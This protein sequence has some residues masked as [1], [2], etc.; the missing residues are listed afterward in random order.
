MRATLKTIAEATGFSINTVS[1]VLRNDGRI[2]QE[3][4]QIIRCKADELGY[5][6]DAIASSMR[7]PRTRTIGVVSADL[8]NPF[9]S[10]VIRGIE[11]RAQE[12]GYQMLIGNTEE[13]AEREEHLIRLFLSRKVDGLIIMP[14]YGKDRRQLELY[15]SL[16]VP[17][18]FAGRYIEGLE[19]HSVLHSDIEGEQ[20]VFD[21]LLSRGHSHILYLSG[22]ECISNTHDRD[23]G[24]MKAYESRSLIPD[25]K[26]IFHL[27]GHP[28]DGYQAVNYAINLSMEFTAV[29]CFNDIVAMGVLKSLAENDLSVPHDIEVIGYDNLMFSQFMQPSLSTVDVPKHR[30]GYVAME[31]LEKHMDNP[32]MEYKTENLPAR[33][34]FRDSTAGERIRQS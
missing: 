18:I 6:P 22:P 32:S 19:S 31:L 29:A 34:L 15:A 5:I 3:T 28:E 17:F 11:E 20:S 33:L 16:P 13:D 7:N 30:L 14:S 2:S 25:Q 10:E 23:K 12:T 9:F 4:S 24:M 21:Y 26:Y 1:R 27:P 8:S